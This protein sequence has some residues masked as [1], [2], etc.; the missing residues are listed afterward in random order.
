MIWPM[1][2]PGPSSGDRNGREAMKP[3]AI[4]PQP[5]PASGVSRLENQLP[6]PEALMMP[7]SIATKPMKGMTVPSMVCTASRAA[8]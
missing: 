3:R 7:I 5:V 1:T 4:S 2:A 8:W 6:K